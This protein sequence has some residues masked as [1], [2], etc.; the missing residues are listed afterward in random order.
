[1][2]YLGADAAVE[3][4]GCKPEEKADCPQ[5]SHEHALEA[6]VEE[7]VADGCEKRTG[8]NDSL[9]TD[10]IAEASCDDVETDRDHSTRYDDEC[11]LPGCITQ[12]LLHVFD[13]K[14]AGRSHG[15]C[16][17]KPGEQHRDHTSWVFGRDA[18]DQVP[19]RCDMRC[20]F[21]HF[22]RPYFETLCFRKP[23]AQEG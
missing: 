8:H 17:A 19:S 13:S 5:R 2:K 9:A 18:P 23:P 20:E 7:R 6:A 10:A 21:P 22:V 4:V 16:P 3:R 1:G 11:G 12:C 14:R 15:R